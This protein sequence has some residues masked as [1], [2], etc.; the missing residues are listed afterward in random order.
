MTT[1]TDT[2]IEAALV[3]VIRLITHSTCVSSLSTFKVISINGQLVYFFLRPISVHGQLV[4]IR[5]SP[6]SH[7][8]G[9]HQWPSRV[10]PTRTSV[11]IKVPSLLHK[12][13]LRPTPATSS[14]FTGEVVQPHVSHLSSQARVLT[15]SQWT[16]ITGPIMHYIPGATY[17]SR[18][19]YNSNAAEWLKISEQG[20]QPGNT[21][22]YQA[23]L[24][25]AFTLF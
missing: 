19:S 8:S 21:S 7:S 3:D 15:H 17:G 10:R 11:V 13:P 23:E 18:A 22:C 16:H 5:P 14:G 20:L 12:I 2:S 25:K 4:T 1:P 6:I 9:H 24:C